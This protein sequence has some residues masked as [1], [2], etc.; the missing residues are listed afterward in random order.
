MKVAEV[1]IYN[2]L[3]QA[4]ER[5]LDAAQRAHRRNRGTEL[6]LVP[7][8]NAI[9]EGLQHSRYIYLASL[10]IS[11]EF[12][13]VSHDLRIQAL[14]D[15]DA[16]RYCA[17]FIEVWL[18]GRSFKVRLTSRHGRTYSRSMPI[19]RGLHTERGSSPL[20]VGPLFQ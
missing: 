7:L 15:A 17:R 4:A 9:H 3:I 13:A 6:H 11:G 19:T 12:A 18:K 8:T 2:R 1:A 5:R 20:L 16:E 14:R 10:E